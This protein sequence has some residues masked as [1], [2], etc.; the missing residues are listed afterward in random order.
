MNGAADSAIDAAEAAVLS[1][2]TDEPAAESAAGASR[3]SQLVFRLLATLLVPYRFVR[4]RRLLRV[5]RR[6]TIAIVTIEVLLG[7]EM[8]PADDAVVFV[9]VRHWILL[10]EVEWPSV[11]RRAA[12]LAWRKKKGTFVVPLTRR[13]SAIANR[14]PARR[15]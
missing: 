12:A 3:S 15:A 2:Q 1:H 10:A 4:G 5:L 6:V 13:S 8:R 11:K 14:E 7:V 9:G